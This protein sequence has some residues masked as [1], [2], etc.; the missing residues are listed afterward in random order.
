MCGNS[1]GGVLET[2]GFGEQNFLVADLAEVGD[3]SL[4]RPSFGPI[5]FDE[6]PVGGFFAFGFLGFAEEWS[7]KH[8]A[9]YREME[10]AVKFIFFHYIDFWEKTGTKNAIWGLFA[11][12]MGGLPAM[13]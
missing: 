7:N 10:R 12:K 13:R 3:D 5:R 8:D 9:N 2:E 1:F 4:T 11:F 6:G